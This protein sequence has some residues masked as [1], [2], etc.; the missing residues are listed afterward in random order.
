MKIICSN[1]HQYKSLGNE[2]YNVCN[3][4]AKLKQYAPKTKNKPDKN[5]K[6]GYKAFDKNKI[7]YCESC[8]STNYPLSRS[9]IISV[10]MRPDLASDPHNLVMECFGSKERCHDIWEH[11]TSTQRKK[12]L[13]YERKIAYIQIKGD[14]HALER[15]K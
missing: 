1:C 10:S 7:T 13:T 2:K 3:D 8:G 15:Y 5:R 14:N 11:G 6:K 9:H 12:L 4:C